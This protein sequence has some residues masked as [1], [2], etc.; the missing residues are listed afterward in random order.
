MP[1]KRENTVHVKLS[2]DADKALELLVIT[3]SGG[4][5]KAAIA[6][7]LLER[8]LLGEAHAIRVAV[9]RL[10]RQGIAARIGE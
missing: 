10:S 3:Q 6:A 4:T 2:D 8:C 7:S 5:T 1:D 9:S